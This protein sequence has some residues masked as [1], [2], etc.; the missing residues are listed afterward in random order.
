MRVYV[1]IKILRHGQRVQHNR[2]LRREYNAKVD[3]L[4]HCYYI[5]ELM[6]TISR[7]IKLNNA[8]GGTYRLHLNI[9]LNGAKNTPK[10][11]S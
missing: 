7:I 9:D 1:Q 3:I 4:C 10:H 11:I 6:P 5:D 2:Y 8:T